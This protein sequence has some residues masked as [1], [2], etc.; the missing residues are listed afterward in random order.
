MTLLNMYL[1]ANLLLVL[2][3]GGVSGMR[4]ISA[5]LPRPIAYRQQLLITYAL[6]I[7]VLVLPLCAVLPVQVDGFAANAQVWSGATMHEAAPGERPQLAVAMAASQMSVP[8]NAARLVTTVLL[9]GSAVSFLW[10][11]ALDALRI[12]RLIASAQCIV[13]RGHVRVLASDAVGVP[14]SFWLPSRHVIVVPVELM[15]RPEDLRIALRHEAQH[16]RRLDTKLVYVYQL[17]RAVFL[18]NPAVH[19]LHRSVTE[20][21]EFA[22]DEALLAQRRVSPVAYCNCLLRVAQSAIEQR[23]A[24]LCPSMLGSAPTSTLRTRVEAVLRQPG[25]QARRSSAVVLASLLL[26]VMT[27][28]AVAAS[29]T[30]QDRRISMEQAAAM[31]VAARTG[32]DF[33]IV[34]NARV[35]EQLNRLLGTPDGRAFVRDSLARMQQHQALIAQKTAQYGLPAELLA[36]PL[37]ESGFRNLPRAANPAHGAGIWMFIEP[38]ARRF[39]LTVNGRVDER[40]DVA[41]ETDAAMHMFAGL[42]QTFGDWGLALLAYNAGSKRVQQGI[43]ATGSRDVWQLID[44][45]HENDPDYVARVMA[46]V[47]IIR[48]PTAVE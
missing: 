2:A 21:Q 39:G 33:P 16:H 3:A 18:L 48:N 17:L 23:S 36:V 44:R 4:R 14:F 11:L 1:A 15:L 24:A 43:E 40:L 34:V 20:L 26:A 30:V 13:R 22:C 5:R 38:T 27:G 10:L 8:L 45:G 12:R 25:T 28:A 31:A 7:A 29:A 32:S 6:S 47:L 9:L 35:V 19:W 42:N 46:A 37:A 41:A